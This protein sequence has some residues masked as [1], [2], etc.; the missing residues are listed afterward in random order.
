MSYE[1]WLH[2]CAEAH[3]AEI[4]TILLNVS[5]SRLSWISLSTLVF[6]LSALGC[7]LQMYSLV[8]SG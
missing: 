8:E 3:G 2:K 5:S 7:M 6:S 1:D 4:T